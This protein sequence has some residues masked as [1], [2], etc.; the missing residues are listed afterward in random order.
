MRTLISKTFRR[1]AQAGGGR[2][3]K[4]TNLFLLTMLAMAPMWTVAPR[5]TP[6]RSQAQAPRPKFRK[7]ARAVANRYIVVLNDDAVRYT[8]RDTAVAEIGD[9][10]AAAHGARIERTYKHALN[11]YAMEMAEAQA[12]ALSQ[13]P[14]VAYV[15]EDGVV[16]V[17]PIAAENNVQE[18]A[19]WGLDRIDQ[20]G[21]PLDGD[22]AYNATGRGVHVYVIDTGIRRTHREFQGRAVAAFDSIGDGQNANDCNGHGTHV[23]GTVGGATYGVA[24][25]ARLYSVRVL[26]CDGKGSFSGIIA[27]VDWVTANHIKPAVANMSLGGPASQALDDAVRNSIAAGVT[28]VVAASNEN[29]DACNF[30]PARAPNTIT[31]GAT[32]R[33]D[34]RSSFSNYGA[35]V[36][37]F[38]PGSEITSAGF[39]SDTTTAIM[40]GTSMASPHV[41]GVAALYLEGRPTA[42]PAD[43][44]RAIIGGGSSGRLSDVKAGSPN[45]LLYSL[46]GGA[47]TSETLSTDDGV[48]EGGFVG[49]AQTFVNRLTPSKYPATLQTIRVFFKQFTNAPS[50][51]GAQIRLIAFVGAPGSNRPP[52][53]PTLLLDQRVTIPAIGA[54]G[55]FVDFPI[56][57]SPAINSGDLYVGFQAPNPGG[58]VGAWF[59]DSQPQQQR[60][61]F[62]KDNGATYLGP[63]QKQDGA[64]TNLM[65]RAIVSSGGGSDCAFIISPTTGASAAAG[66]SGTV[67]VTTG[68]GCN[69]T[70][71]SNASFITVRPPASGNGSGSVTY[72]VG[73]NTSA[74]PR[75][76]TLTV[77]GQTFTLT[78]EGAANPQP[79]TRLARIG[80]AGGAP[81]GQISVPIELVAQGDEN[82]LGFSITFDPAV[83]DN[84]QAALGSEAA[85]A[86]LKTNTSQVGAGS[87]G[88]ALSL[89]SGAKFS[90]GARQVA[91]V[92]FSIAGDASAGLTQV[93]FGD[94][95]IAREISDTNAGALQAKY[96]PGAVTITSSP[97]IEGDVAP[98][99]N[100]NGS[101]TVTDWVQIGRFISGEDTPSSVEF[102]RADAAP[103][104]SR[105]N[106]ALTITDWVQAG[107]YAAG[108]DPLTSAGGPSS[109]GSSG[110]AAGSWPAQT[111]P[112]SA[113]RAVR[114]RSGAFERG[115]Q[116]SAIIELDA[117]GNENA[118]GFSLNFDPSQLQFVSATAG[119]DAAGATLNT[120]SS[121]ATNGRLG[122][123]LA[124]PAG[125]TIQ[126]GQRQ[127]LTINFAVAS[128]GEAT[129]AAIGFG[130]LPVAR[131]L[132][133][134]GAN[135]LPA[136]FSGGAITLTRSV[137]S[138]SAAS[139]SGRSLASE[140]IAVAF[141]QKLATG[142]AAATD[143]SS[144]PITLAGTTVKMRD[145]AGEERLAPLFFV[146]PGQVNY[147]IPAGTEPGD[148][149]VT[150]T[151]GDGEVSTGM[152]NVAGVAPGL[153]SAAASGQGAAS[154]FV[155]RI[156]AGGE[157]SY[158][159]VARYDAAQNRFVMQPIDLGAEGDQVFL[160]L[161]G[162][163]FRHQRDLSALKVKLGDVETEALFAGKQGGY[164]GLDQLNLRIPRSLTGHGEIDVMLTADGHE[165]N[166]VKVHIK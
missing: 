8:A 41:A 120:N 123:A 86:T 137:T 36:N 148:A 140:A 96:Q 37:I 162:T 104:D 158:E 136:N 134:A 109:Q 71:T 61:F 46:L 40:N 164:E 62:S 84:P 29:E 18:N 161:F 129:T 131:E 119:K 150:I 74:S 38:A 125:Q 101:V 43:V 48:T 45:L 114:I 95:P 67:N 142:A 102:Q 44:S 112:S 154:A 160:I 124:L 58:G 141:G 163:G 33:F 39:A 7:Q 91:V 127:I 107:R 115:Q 31:V 103:R 49:D 155:F 56:T 97:S 11:G 147:L 93:G 66:A 78:Q 116:S 151:S 92:T 16:I 111:T 105:G 156:K 100:G 5:L 28:Y 14:R 13:D 108:L 17:D 35:C 30:S 135:S 98:R 26:G 75:T 63:I 89:P 20:R 60:G 42:S 59:D 21:L 106:G 1:K 50:P 110:L 132:S 54:N 79:D 139:Y 117:E 2:R 52:N 122:L 165:S 64:P 4:L 80:Q 3:R 65:I 57:N 126:P 9:S 73:A 69:W 145:H 138:V 68:A 94:Q 149:T 130:D 72:S 152:I 83:L 27:G 77:A 70:A 24:K 159:P 85:G 90:A 146:S 47:G 118:L 32:T 128:E 19:T 51:A 12:V 10:F 53:N 153:F 113:A 81:G 82:A 143:A 144:L 6:V 166:R 133:D 157:Q 22:Y 55:A 34:V 15:E 23:A 121:Q 76:G 87:L 88:V 99:P 25:D